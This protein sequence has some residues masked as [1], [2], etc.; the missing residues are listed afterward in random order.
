MSIG[1]TT[2]SENTKQRFFLTPPPLK[3]RKWKTPEDCNLSVIDQG[4]DGYS[5]AKLVRNS[6]Q[7]NKDI[8]FTVR[9]TKTVIRSYRRNYSHISVALFRT[10][11][12]GPT[13]AN[14]EFMNCSFLEIEGE[15]SA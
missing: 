3:P 4:T 13:R 7:T 5:P 8:Y 12:G 9:T 10:K 1:N 6:P 15:S 14:I 2:P 11:A